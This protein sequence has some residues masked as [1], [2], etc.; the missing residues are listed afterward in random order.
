MTQLCRLSEAIGQDPE[1]AIRGVLQS[2]PYAIGPHLLLSRMLL[3]RG[4]IN[5]AMP[6]LF[7]LERL[8]NPEG[9]YSLGMVHMQNL[10]LWGALVHFAKAAELNPAHEPSQ[11][12][13]AELRR[14][15]AEQVPAKI[16]LDRKALLTGPH[17]GT[18]AKAKIRCS[19]VIVTFNSALTIQECLTSLLRTLG[20]NDEIIVVDNASV[21]GTQAMVAELA[22]CD[23]RIHVITSEH[24]QGYSRAMNLGILATKGEF[25]TMM[26]PDAYVDA[27]W[28]EGLSHHLG[29][30]VVAVGPVSD[31]VGG[32]QFVG[33]W[34]GGERPSVEDLQ[35]VLRQTKLGQS[36]ETKFLVG[37]CLLMKRD[38]LNKHGLLDETTELGADDLELSWRLGELGYRMQIALDVFVRHDQGVSFA[39]LAMD[40]KSTRQGRSDFALI[41][42][43]EAYYGEDI[44]S[45]NE[46]WGC[47]IFDEALERREL[48]FPEGSHD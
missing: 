23:N 44:P 35:S 8:G 27:N 21:D 31:N 36:V 15:L 16:E 37:L 20:T 40:E 9:A 5:G 25:I 13:L 41:R 10:N 46:L 34:L 39:S 32:D 38:T 33:H 18:L 7:E 22:G 42:K 45:S 30:E 28:F 17:S 24:N 4:D 12:H 48:L 43:L 11:Q 1:V 19:V 47:P 6:H 29:G 14:V 2:Y 3:T 26:N